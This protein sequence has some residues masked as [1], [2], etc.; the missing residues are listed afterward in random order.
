[1]REDMEVCERLE[2]E[3][4]DE[5]YMAELCHRYYAEGTPRE[6]GHLLRRSSARLA[7]RQGMG[8]DGSRVQRQ[9]LH[10]LVV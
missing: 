10:M 9:R 6:L 3:R 8:E 2:A 1:M 7:Q 5:E 4:T